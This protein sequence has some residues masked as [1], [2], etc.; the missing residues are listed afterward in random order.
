MQAHVMEQGK[1][2]TSHGSTQGHPQPD[3]ICQQYAQ[4]VVK[5][6]FATPQTAFMLAYSL[7]VTCS[8]GLCTAA[9]NAGEA[10]QP[11]G[12]SSS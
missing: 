4:E 8:S 12:N 11:S 1:Q 5:N 10:D 7:K 6:I 3:K 9:A 2:S